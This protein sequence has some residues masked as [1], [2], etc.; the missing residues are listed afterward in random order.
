M[1]E[2]SVV[3]GPHGIERLR[4][5]HLWVYRSDVRSANAETGAIVRL[6]DERG[7]FQGRAFYSDKSQI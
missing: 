4:S 5:G 3:I 6:T 7:H 1:A 2:G